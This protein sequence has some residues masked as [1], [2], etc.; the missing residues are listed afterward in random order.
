MAYFLPLLLPFPYLVN[1]FFWGNGSVAGNMDVGVY[2][3]GGK[4]IASTGAIA[5][6]PASDLQY[7]APSGG[8]FYL[9]PG[10][11]LLAISNNGTANRGWGTTTLT[12][13]EA[14]MIGI[15]SMASAHALPATATLAIQA[16]S[17]WPAVGITR[18]TT[19][20]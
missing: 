7:A 17:I 6:T 9:D 5:Q 16:N 1:R 18:T 2:T 19:G 3:R 10:E 4:L 20:F 11:Y 12:N 13:L 8:A 15:Y 14:R